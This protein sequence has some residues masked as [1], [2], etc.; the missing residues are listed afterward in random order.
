MMAMKM[1]IIP[2]NRVF[3][4]GKSRGGS[5]TVFLFR[6]KRIAIIKKKSGMVSKPKNF[7]RSRFMASEYSLC[8]TL[9]SIVLHKS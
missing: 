2:R 6:I 5:K 1:G 3:N 9:F 7:E 4:M 8:K